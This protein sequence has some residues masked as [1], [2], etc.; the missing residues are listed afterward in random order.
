MY[1]PPKCSQFWGKKERNPVYKFDA[2]LARMSVLF[3]MLLQSISRVFE[4]G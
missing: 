2:S 1:L 3:F 4:P